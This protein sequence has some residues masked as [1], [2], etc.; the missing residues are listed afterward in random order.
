MTDALLA[1]TSPHNQVGDGTSFSPAGVRYVRSLLFYPSV[2]QRLYRSSVLSNSIMPSRAKKYGQSCLTCR[3]RKVRCGGETPA[4]AKC[5]RINERC[6][7]SAHDSTVTR[8]QNALAKSEL[9]LQELERDL[10]ALLMLEP[11]ECREA[12]RNITESFDQR[13]DEAHHGEY[14]VS[15]T[16][17]RASIQGSGNS[18]AA[19]RPGQQALVNDDGSTDEEE[20]EEV[21]S[22]KVLLWSILILLGVRR[23]FKISHRR[24]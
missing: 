11:A 23:N 8:L 24:T 9:R 5:V 15:G 18:L 20:N 21:H 12:L 6:V 4:C 13:L 2:S 1:T 22:P 14:A 19:R 17:D 16:P 10:R 3:R 7:Y